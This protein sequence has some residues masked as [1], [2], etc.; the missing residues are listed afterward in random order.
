MLDLTFFNYRWWTTFVV[1]INLPLVFAHVLEIYIAQRI[2]SLEKPLK[3][4]Q[5]RKSAHLE[6]SPSLDYA[7]ILLTYHHLPS[8]FLNKLQ[9][10]LSSPHLH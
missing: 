1:G 10:N 5:L 2:L 8:P 9:P 7:V 4:P 6:A 3:W